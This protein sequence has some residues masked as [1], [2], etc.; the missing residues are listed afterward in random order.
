MIQALEVRQKL[1]AFLSHQLSLD[2]FEDWL[3]GHSWNM[4]VDSSAEVNDLVS[5]IELA[6]SEHSSQH[7][8]ESELRSKLFK[9]LGEI[10]VQVTIAND[11]VTVTLA[12]RVVT[13]NSAG[14]PRV[15][16][17]VLAIA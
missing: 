1:R 11:R 14:P 7:L 17:R 2:D 12:R 13:A 8:D 9:V 4:H 10:V 5:A 3:V 15:A 6:L 16:G